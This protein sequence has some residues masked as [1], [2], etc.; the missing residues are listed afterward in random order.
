MSHVWAVLIASV[1]MF[2]WGSLAY[3]KLLF[4]DAWIKASGIDPSEMNIS[5]SKMALT[6]GQGFLA[7]VGFITIFRVLM[8]MLEFTALLELLQLGVMLFLFSAFIRLRNVSYEGNYKLYF[9]TITI[10]FVDL[11]IASV[12]FSL[13]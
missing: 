6:M 8:T 12:V 7:S 10:L 9:I 3:S 1:L 5:A 4:G 11:V 13:I 2:V